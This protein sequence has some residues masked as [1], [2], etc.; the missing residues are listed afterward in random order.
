M[1]VFMADRKE[2]A[3]FTVMVMVEDEYGRV[4]V[5]NKKSDSWGGLVFPGGHVERGE[6][7]TDA[8]VREVREETGLSIQ[9]PRI[10]AVKQFVLDDY[11][12]VVHL[13]R[14][15]KFC[16]TL[17]GSDEGEVFFLSREELL[18]RSDE[19]PISFR[20][21]LDIFF[22]RIDATEHCMYRENGEWKQLFK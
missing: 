3:E 10:I 6:F 4:L 17:S 18:S 16:G 21:M 13:F 8:A 1:E 9:D 20:E 14:A 7:F 19:M 2:L 15:T 11:R 22:G 12:Y 5:Q